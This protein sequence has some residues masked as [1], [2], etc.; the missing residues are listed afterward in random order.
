MRAPLAARSASATGA[1][2]TAALSRLSG[3]TAEQHDDCERSHA[4]Q[5][6]VRGGSPQRHRRLRPRT[7]R[8]LAR[9]ARGRVVRVPRP[10][11]RARKRQR[12]HIEPTWCFL[13]LLTDAGHRRSKNSSCSSRSRSSSSSSINNTTVA[14]AE[15]RKNCNPIRALTCGTTDTAA[16]RRTRAQRRSS[17]APPPPPLP[18]PRRSAVSGPRA[19]PPPQPARAAAATP[20]PRRAR[21]RTRRCGA[22]SRASRCGA[23]PRAPTTA[24]R[25][26]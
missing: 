8:D 7:V 12:K 24:A 4:N 19:T 14:V 13:K 20:P 2:I 25:A 26:H 5:P 11:A 17:R 9:D 18:T 23:A 1:H 3:G 16:R 6:T 15:A 21:P 22:Q 10:P